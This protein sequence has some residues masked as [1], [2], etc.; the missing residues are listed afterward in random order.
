MARID[1][2]IGATGVPSQP[3][4]RRS[5][6]PHGRFRRWSSIMSVETYGDVAAVDDVSFSLV[7]WRDSGPWSATPAQASRPCC[8]LQPVSNVLNPAASSSK[9]ARSP[10]AN[11]F[12]PPERRGIGLMFQDY[13][14]FPH[15]TVLRKR[16]IRSWQVS[17]GQGQPR[18]QGC[19]RQNR[20]CRAGQRISTHA[21]RR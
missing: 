20:T 9:I 6:N 3:L 16:Q 14:L 10:A 1:T 7:A 21:V 13:A 8:A 17:A 19:P 12:V 11:G 4:R 2:R 5:T 15:M 18:R